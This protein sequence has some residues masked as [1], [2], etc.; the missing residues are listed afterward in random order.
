MQDFHLLERLAH[1]YPER[2][3]ECIYA[4]ARLRHT[5]LSYPHHEAEVLQKGKKTEAFLR[6]Y[7][8][9]GNWDLVGN[10]TLVFFVR[11]ALKFLDF[12]HTQKRQ[13]RTNM[14]S[15]TAMWDFWSLPSV[16]IMR[17]KRCRQA[18]V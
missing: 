1:Q 17:G 9:E 12:I 3:P 13:P 5:R 11:D 18:L 6:F 16:Q 14:R 7:I 8:E 10:N 4:K 15:P 2:I